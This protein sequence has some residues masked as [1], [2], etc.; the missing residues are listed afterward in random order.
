MFS[1]LLALLIIWLF[2][3]LGIGML[4]IVG[5][6]II[7][8]LLFAFVSYLVL[9]LLALIALGGLIGLIFAH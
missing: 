1:L 2:W 9:P 5:F 8:G 6:L 3:K 7:V 4:K